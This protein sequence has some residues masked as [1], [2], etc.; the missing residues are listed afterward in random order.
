MQRPA[1]QGFAKK[2]GLDL[3][4]DRLYD[5]D[6]ARHVRFGLTESQHDTLV[7]AY[8]RGYNT[9]PRETDAGELAAELGISH[10]AVGKRLRRATG[11]LIESTLLVDE[12]EAE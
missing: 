1:I 8:E 12:N 9:I 10:Q 2:H 11:N 3:D 5:V 4:V 7:K 6:D